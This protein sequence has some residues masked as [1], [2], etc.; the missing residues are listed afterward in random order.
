[1][2]ATDFTRW[3]LALFFL[4]VAVFYTV[5]IL[6][7]SRRVGGPPVFVGTPGTMDLQ[8]KCNASVDG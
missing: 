4:A 8:I 5:R 6:V 1:M 2:M 7:A 3:F